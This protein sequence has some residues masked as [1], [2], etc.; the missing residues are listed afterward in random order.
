MSSQGTQRVVERPHE[1]LSVP[2]SLGVVGRAEDLLDPEVLTEMVQQLRAE[3]WP[4]LRQYALRAA[5]SAD[6]VHVAEEVLSTSL[7]KVV[8]VCC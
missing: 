4:V 3:T 1:P 5:M 2:I 6:H 8:L 7:Y